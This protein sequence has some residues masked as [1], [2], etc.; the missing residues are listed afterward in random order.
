M[1]LGGK[2]EFAS[3]IG[4]IKSCDLNF[5]FRSVYSNTEDT[6]AGPS[7]PH[8]PACDNSRGCWSL[9]DLCQYN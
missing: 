2:A 3:R 7:L 8:D 9:Q 1:K 6:R 5:D 4:L